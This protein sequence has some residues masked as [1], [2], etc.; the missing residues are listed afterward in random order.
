M[1]LCVQDSMP[2]SVQ[3]SVFIPIAAKDSVWK[4]LV[5]LKFKNEK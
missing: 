4:E 3:A 1:C 2:Q 5:F